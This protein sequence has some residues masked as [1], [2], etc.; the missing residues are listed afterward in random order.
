[1]FRF[2]CRYTTEDCSEANSFKF[3]MKGDRCLP[4]CVGI[5]G[6]ATFND[7]CANHG[8]FDA[9]P[10]YDAEFCCTKQQ[11]CAARTPPTCEETGGSSG[12][13]DSST[14]MIIAIVGVSG[15][16]ACCCPR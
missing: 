1:M 13:D 6:E 5:G 8:M 14:T 4:S 3:K 7:A 12:D 11:M 9:G 16:A 10:A 2:A 15:H